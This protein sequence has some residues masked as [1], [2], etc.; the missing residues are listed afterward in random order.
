VAE[1]IA[2]AAAAL[3]VELVGERENDL[4]AGLD[5]PLPGGVDVLPVGRR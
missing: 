4:G 5:G 3:A 1:G 2:Q